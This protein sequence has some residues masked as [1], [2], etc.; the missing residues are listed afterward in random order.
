[1]LVCTKYHHHRQHGHSSSGPIIASS[2]CKNVM[3]SRRGLAARTK[4]F[5]TE[6]ERT[7]MC[8]FMELHFLFTFYA[9]LFFFLVRAYLFS[10]WVYGRNVEQSSE[11]ED[12]QKQFDMDA[13]CM[14][15][16]EFGFSVLFFLIKSIRLAGTKA[17]KQINLIRNALD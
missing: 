12:I 11:S 7:K 15:G 5:E 17:I 1:M 9:L 16:T 3:L 10:Q 4:F 2:Y 6:S 14:G 13:G 8:Y